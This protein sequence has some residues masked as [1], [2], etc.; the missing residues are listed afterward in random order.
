[1]NWIFLSITIGGILSMLLTPLFIRFQK[2]RAIGE[3]IRID[4]PRTHSTKAGTPTMGGIVI[5]FA[6]IAAFIIVSLKIL[7]VPGLQHGGD[8]YYFHTVTVQ[9]TGVH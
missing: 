9:C 4:G 3:K 7:P 5:V 1:M 2:G 8:I 6:S